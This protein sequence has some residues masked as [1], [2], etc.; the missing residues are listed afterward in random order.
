V[1][2]EGKCSNKVTGLDCNNQSAL[3]TKRAKVTLV[4]L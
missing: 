2:Y 4:V 3:K 1:S